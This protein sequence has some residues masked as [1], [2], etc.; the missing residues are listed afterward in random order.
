[1]TIFAPYNYNWALGNSL[2]AIDGLVS[3]KSKLSHNTFTSAFVIMGS[4]GKVH[5][6]VTD[7]LQDVQKFVSSGG[8]L[9]LSFG[10]AAG[11]FLENML[12]EDEQFNLTDKLISQTKC[13]GIDYD[14][15]GAEIAMPN[16]INQRNNVIKRI[17]SKYPNLYVSFTLPLLGPSNSGGGLDFN[18]LAFVKSAL[19]SGVK[20]DIINVM[21]MDAN[22]SAPTGDAYIASIESLKSQL[23]SLLPNKSDSDIYGMIGITPMIGVNDD[24]TITKVEDVAKMAAYAKQ[25]NCGLF[26]FWSIQRDQT[27]TGQLGVYSKVNTLNFDFFNAVKSNLNITTVSSL[28][29]TTNTTTPQP[30]PTTDPNANSQIVF[31]DIV[32]Y[33]GQTFTCIIYMNGNL[34]LTPYTNNSNDNTNSNGNTNGNTNGNSNGNSNGNTNGNTTSYPSWTLNTSYKAGDVVSYNGSNYKC[35]QNHTSISPN[36]TPSDVASLWT[37]I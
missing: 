14:V 19:N 24:S 5:S 36:W 25:K 27:G 4:D 29:N 37:K 10:G 6:N 15:E 21:A 8:E 34:T 30:P 33:N 26:S 11:P 1:M 32:L 20:P 9:I 23:K 17:V 31:N 18:G 28:K 22:V 35:I 12:T 16:S 2:Y 13:V 7:S 3:A